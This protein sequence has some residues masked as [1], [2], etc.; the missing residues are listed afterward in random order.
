MNRIMSTFL[1]SAFLL[2]SIGPAFAGEVDVIDVKV[3]KDGPSSFYF[4]VTLEHGDEGWDHYADAWEVVG[5]DGKVLGKRTLYHPHVNEQPFTRSLGGV[6]I[7]KSITEVYIRG[8]DS[9]HRH[10]GKT[11]PVKVP[12]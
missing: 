3:K 6:E 11:M 2:M 1:F 12:H 8:H 4:S 9:V 5:P 10:G 7:D